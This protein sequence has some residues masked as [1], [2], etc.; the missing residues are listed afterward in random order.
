MRLHILS[1]LHLEFGNVN[2]PATDADVVV[3]AGDIHQ[4][5]NG[6]EWACANF[7]GQPVVYVA[8]NHELYH[9]S[10]PGV[11]EEIRTACRG[12][13]VHFL[14]RGTVTLGEYTFLGCTLWTDFCLFGSENQVDAWAQ[15]AALITDYRRIRLEPENRL[16]RSN[17]T[18][19]WHETSRHWLEQEIPG[20]D[21]RHL[22]VVT[23]HAP[24]AMSIPPH[25]SKDLL[26]A[27]FASKLD[28]L[29]ESSGARLWVHGHTHCSSHYWLGRT[30]V[31]SNQRGYPGEVDPHFKSGLIL[32]I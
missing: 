3:L 32:E 16:L 25:R 12:T 7:P 14:E 20:H 1:D 4:G 8:G 30:Q 22:I 19:I 6:V 26:S 11:F 28:S 31:A 27:A 23:H 24:S 21:L 15:A 2:I 29:V 17:D 5:T 9:R 13:Q 18:V 10:V